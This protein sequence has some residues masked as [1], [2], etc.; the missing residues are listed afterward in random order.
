ME[1]YVES[2]LPLDAAV[3]TKAILRARDKLRY[4]PSI[5]ELREFIQIE[6]RATSTEDWRLLPLVSIP[7]PEWVERW[8]RARAVGDYRP[9]PEQ[10]SA[11]TAMKVC[12]V[13]SVTDGSVW[14]QENEYE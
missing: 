7:R 8:A 13:E 10:M 3:T 4:R 6:H 11:L 5:A 12:P 2:L 9:F 1:A 14:V